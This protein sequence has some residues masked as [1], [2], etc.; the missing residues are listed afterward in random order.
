MRQFPTNSLGPLNLDYLD[1]HVSKKRTLQVALLGLALFI[2]L[3]SAFAIVCSMII[4]STCAL[5]L[6][7]LPFCVYSGTELLSIWETTND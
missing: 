6:T 7:V 2:V 1:R 4:D 5:L 3:I